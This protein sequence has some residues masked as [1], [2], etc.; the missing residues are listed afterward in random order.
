MVKSLVGIESSLGRRS[1][2]GI[3]LKI[4]D[5]VM[6]NRL[7]QSEDEKSLEEEPDEDVSED[8]GFFQTM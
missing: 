8:E 4:F 1:G 2:W 3:R 5:L 6:Q 7:E